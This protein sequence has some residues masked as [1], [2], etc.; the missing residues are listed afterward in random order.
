MTGDHSIRSQRHE[1]IH[2]LVTVSITIVGVVQLAH[3]LSLVGNTPPLA[4]VCKTYVRTITAAVT[5]VT[6][7]G[8]C[9]II[10][11]SPV[12]TIVI[13][14]GHTLDVAVAAEMPECSFA[15]VSKTIVCTSVRIYKSHLV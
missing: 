12:L 11:P 14:I 10:V 6:P 15:P 1:G 8:T 4:V 2:A 7:Y 9:S 13:A 5:H 3:E